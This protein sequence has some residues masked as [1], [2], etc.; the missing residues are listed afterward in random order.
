VG[1]QGEQG[2]AGQPGVAGAQGPPGP[3]GPQGIQ[4]EPGIN[5]IV[6]VTSD[7]GD[8]ELSDEGTQTATAACSEAGVTLR[9]IGGGA[10]L[11]GSFS[12][13][14]IVASRPSGLEGEVPGAWM[15][16]AQRMMG[17]EAALWTVRAYAICAEVNTGDE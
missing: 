2:T 7:D 14:G 13:V 10:L 6:I 17:D 16:T 5:N 8:P 4:G 12:G 1:P 9:A 15:V 11:V 3:H